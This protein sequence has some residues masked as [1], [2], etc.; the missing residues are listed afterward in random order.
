MISPADCV[1]AAIDCDAERAWENSARRILPC[2]LGSAAVH[3]VLLLVLG[4]A[5]LNPQLLGRVVETVGTAS[6]DDETAA[7]EVV[8]WSGDD[9]QSELIDKLVEIPSPSVEQPADLRVAQSDTVAFM[10][11]PVTPDPASDE[12]RAASDAKESV[13]DQ[14]GCLGDPSGNDQE[15]PNA[16]PAWKPV[17]PL[18]NALPAPVTPTTPAHSNRAAMIRVT[19]YSYCE[20]SVSAGMTW[21]IAQQGSD[22]SWST[23]QSDRVTATSLALLPLLGAGQ[24]HRT[25]KYKK[26]VAKA[27][28]NLRAA[29]ESDQQGSAPAWCSFALATLVLCENQAM[30]ASPETQALAQEALDRLCA[31]QSTRDGKWLQANGSEVSASTRAW[32]ALAI[33]SGQLAKLRVAA[34]VTRRLTADADQQCAELAQLQNPQASA[35]TLIPPLF[36]GSQSSQAAMDRCIDR[37]AAT[38]P[39]LSRLQETYFATLLVHHRHSGSR[40]E[41]HNQVRDVL[42]NQ[43]NWH[44]PHRGAWLD[45]PQAKAGFGE[46][47]PDLQRTVLSMM[48]ME[49]Y[50]RHMPIYG[51]GASPL[52]PPKP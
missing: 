30:T 22:G 18:P 41:W 10:Y 44:S 33:R 35:A 42:I 25:G 11:P 13:D 5:T 19:G 7:I 21:L 50:Y 2:W 49:I 20:G 23:N 1:L 24:T 45:R 38:G 32:I 48:T 15:V 12:A 51:L 31:A 3:L 4:V 8:T 46:G 6:V 47:E 28:V 16:A 34:E 26:E 27:L 52:Y 37:L 40:Q 36:F 29:F 9:S 17:V 14:P 43:Q 39:D